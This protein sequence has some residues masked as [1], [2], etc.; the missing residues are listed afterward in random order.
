MAINKEVSEYMRKIG[1]KGRKS[2]WSKLTPKQRSEYMRKLGLK[3]KK[4]LSPDNI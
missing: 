4:K 3:R 2:R 1:I